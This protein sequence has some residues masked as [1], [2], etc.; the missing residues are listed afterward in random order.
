MN[1]KSFN[2][3]KKT[4]KVV[5]KHLK[6]SKIKKVYKDFKNNLDRYIKERKFAVAVSGGPDS[7][8]LTFL[9]KCYADE[10]NIDVFYYTIDHKLRKNSFEE[11]KKLKS[12]LKKNN[13]KCKIIFWKGKKP[14]SNIQSIA[15]NNRYFLLEKECVKNSIN[16]ILVG[17]HLDDLYEN[18]FIRLFRGSGLKGL[19]SFNNVFTKRKNNINIL[20]P[21]LNQK[22]ENLKYISKSVFNFYVDD[23]S[24]YNDIF[25]R[26]RVRKLINKF[27]KEGFD[28]NKLKLTLNNLSSTNQSINYYVEKNIKLNSK[29][30]S[31]KLVCILKNTFFMEADEVVFRSFSKVLQNMGQKYYESRG[32]TIIMA[33]KKINSKKFD[34]ITLSGCVVEKVNNS[35][36]IYKENAKKT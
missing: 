6:D 12:I 18:F 15:R 27:E 33:L 20:R 5:N 4:H 14:N 11:A 24:N 8:A 3:K 16:T 34:K 35:V 19:S 26:V 9:S 7:L 10:K 32:K 13:I 22:K 17:H 28:E 29:L 1:K 21:L 25:T 23:I 30:I 36:I 2:A 31:N